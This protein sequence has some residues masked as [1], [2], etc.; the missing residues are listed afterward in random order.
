MR[1]RGLRF[2][3]RA[4]A[5]AA[6][7]AGALVTTSAGASPT[8]N[9]W[10]VVPLPSSPAYLSPNRLITYAVDGVG[11]IY[12]VPAGT[13]I[14]FDAVSARTAHAMQSRIS[15]QVSGSGCGIERY[16]SST[17][18]T[19]Q[20]DPT[21]DFQNAYDVAVDPAGN[22]FVLDSGGTIYEIA[23]NGSA[24]TFE[25][26]AQAPQ[27]TTGYG[28]I[29]IAVN[30]SD[31]VFVTASTSGGFPSSVYEV[32]SAGAT[33]ISLANSPDWL[34]PIAVAPD[35]TIYV[36]VFDGSKYFVSRLPVGGVLSS[37]GTGWGIPA[38]IT[39]DAAGNVYVADPPNHVVTEITASG[40][41]SNLPIVP[42]VV[43]TVSYPS[44]ITYGGGTVYLWDGAA[45][46][47]NVLYAWT[48]GVAHATNLSATATAVRVNGTETQTVSASWTGGA[49]SYRCTLLY[50]YNNPTTFTV[51]TSTPSCSFSNLALGVAWG[52]SVVALSNGVASAPSVTFTAPATFTITCVYRGHLLHRTGTNPSCPP[53]W[54]LRF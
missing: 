38:T 9:G 26:T 40:V 34:G 13:C 25:S 15:N 52:I 14:G 27:F 6:L 42:V 47:S 50:G 32:P 22:V 46:S 53:R 16:T 48:P 30:G 44:E 43:G 7:M 23:V 18:A 36:G 1:R 21:Q 11:N 45:G 35:G 41:Q 33:P 39:V 31:Q 5:L 51:M 3:G 19:V 17:G 49:A 20:L 29:G 12:Y 10:S 24:T 28:A 2:G 8:P 54:R 4:L 37:I